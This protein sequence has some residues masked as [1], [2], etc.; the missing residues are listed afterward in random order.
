MTL[1]A[2]IALRAMPAGAASS[3]E[4]GITYFEPIPAFDSVAQN[5]TAQRGVTQK[6]SEER[7]SFDAYGRHFELQLEPNDRIAPLASRKTNAQPLRLMRGT[8]AGQPGS[9]VRLAGSDQEW[10]GMIW[11]GTQLYV[12]EAATAVRDSLLPPLVVGD[13]NTIIFRLA[14]TLPGTIA[15]TCETPV[16]SGGKLVS[17]Q[18]AYDGLIRELH[19]QATSS[20]AMQASGATLRLEMSILGDAAFS[21]QYASDGQARNEI[22][23]RM[24]NVDGIYSSQLGV[25]VQA[26]IVR[27][28]AAATQALTATTSAAELLDE[29]GKLRDQSAELRS[30]GLTHLFTGRDLDG[31]TVGIA[32]RDSLCQGRL[33]V[34]LTEARKRGA[35][36]ESL[37]A[38]HEIGHNFGAVHDGDAPSAGSPDCSST[39]ADQFLMSPSVNAD[40]SIFSQ[41]SL[42]A[43]QP[44]IQAASCISALPPADLAV[45]A[46]L[47][48]L[49]DSVS[50]SFDLVIPITNVGGMTATGARADLL[51]PPSV[52]VDDSSVVGGNCIS[53]AGVI[54]CEM[55]DIPG[56]ATAEIQLTL[57]SD[58]LGSNSI[59]IK[60]SADSDAQLTNNH[61]DGTLSIDPEVDLRTE[62]Q[63]PHTAM[64]RVD[65]TASFS[66]ANLMTIDSG[67]VTLDIELPASVVGLS[68]TLGGVA[69]TPVQSSLIRCNASSIAA[70]GTSNGT[71]TLYPRAAGAAVIRVRSA[72][73]DIDPST[74]DNVAERTVSIAAVAGRVTSVHT[75][76]GVE[77]NGGGAIDALLTLA[78]TLLAGARASR[79]RTH[80]L[81]SGR[82]RPLRRMGHG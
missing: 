51:V 31:T 23:T 45:A 69:C 72:S 43:M 66:V 27:T 38:A 37:I 80:T 11:D 75:A 50:K 30:K 55:D 73:T 74:A 54:H 67:A 62:L 9:W 33:G 13:S 44:R 22:L 71:I 68:A 41:C 48:T 34:G 20:I 59:S 2:A 15:V 42:S 47:G 28:D 5:T 29:L 77:R 49:H 35:W 39:P 12:V 76:T 10:R 79:R 70:N 17:G 57:R 46:D 14:D 81:T 25:A 64:V 36:F 58:I 65:F 60:V 8:L 21:S 82:S 16:V 32:Y 52:I 63:A 56:G 4:I 61:G 40:H 1:I 18:A 78:L 19:K 26:P 53:G 7:L 6:T 24:N 3:G